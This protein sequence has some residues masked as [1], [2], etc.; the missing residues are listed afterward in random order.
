M[1]GI[2]NKAIEEL[3]V[4]HFGV[5]K[6][7]A[8]LISSGVEIDF[9]ISNEPYDDEITFRLASAASGV[10]QMPLPEIMCALGEWWIIHTGRNQYGYLLESGGENLKKFLVHLPLFHNRVMMIYPKLTPPEFKISDVSEQ[11]LLV[12]YFSKREGLKDFV[13]G[14]LVGLGKFYECPVEITL[15]KDRDLG[16]SHEIFK[17]EWNTET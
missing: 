5:E 11:S 9:F 3:V 1:Y 14:L 12:H 8:I 10:L 4:H 7:N 16:D 17:V 6:W 15:I 13:R 2:V